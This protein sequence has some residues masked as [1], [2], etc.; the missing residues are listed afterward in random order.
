[1]KK[2]NL[3]WLLVLSLFLVIGCTKDDIDSPNSTVP[4]PSGTVTLSMYAWDGY[5]RTDLYWYN[6]YYCCPVNLKTNT[7]A[8]REYR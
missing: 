8:Y 7:K 1:M 2:V 5:A 3:V 4:D 6:R